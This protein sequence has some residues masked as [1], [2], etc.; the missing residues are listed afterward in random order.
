MHGV[1][2][3]GPAGDVGTV[4][5]TDGT[6]GDHDG[7]GGFSSRPR[8][9]WIETL[10]RK[11]AQHNNTCASVPPTQQESS[12]STVAPNDGSSSSISTAASTLSPSSFASEVPAPSVGRLACFLSCCVTCQIDCT[13]AEEEA[14]IE[15]LCCD[16][17]SAASVWL[18]FIIYYCLMIYNISYVVVLCCVG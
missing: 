3:I 17:S 1:F 10:I 11:Y 8:P 12:S 16:M 14:L 4:S 7:E 2:V 5:A 6:E 15:V 18:L 13:R 9:Q